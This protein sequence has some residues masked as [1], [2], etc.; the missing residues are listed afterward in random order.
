MIFQGF[1]DHKFQ[2]PFLPQI[3]AKC[4]I[5]SHEIIHTL[6]TFIHHNVEWLRRLILAKRS[7][8]MAG[9]HEW[10]KP[11]TLGR[12]WYVLWLFCGFFFQ[13]KALGWW[14]QSIHKATALRAVQE[15]SWGSQKASS[16]CTNG[17]VHEDSELDVLRFEEG[18][19][20]AVFSDRPTLLWCRIATV[21]RWWLCVYSSVKTKLLWWLERLGQGKR[22]SMHSSSFH[23]RR[24]I[25]SSRIPQFVAYSDLPHTRGKLV[26]CTQPRRV[27]AMSVAKR[28]ADEMD[29]ALQ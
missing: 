19:E 6:H 11:R 14:C 9:Y 20:I 10:W 26:A 17:R 28:V 25:Y 1:P 29:G 24:L 2:L 13:R 15:D 3:L 16:F 4:R 5:Q 18:F 12:L 23:D 27:A 7:L 21:A 8:S 22:H